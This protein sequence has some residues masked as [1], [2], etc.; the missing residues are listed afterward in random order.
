MAFNAVAALLAAEEVTATLVLSAMVE[1]GTTMSIVGAVTGSKDLMKLGGALAIVGGVGGLVNGAASAAGSSVVD[2]T[3]GL[4]TAVG[5]SVPGQI[6]ADAAGNTGI[7][8]STGG[9]EDVAA[10]A[11]DT[12]AS[13]ISTNATTNSLTP[14]SSTPMSPEQD[15]GTFAPN[16]QQANAMPGS[17]AAPGAQTATNQMQVQAPQ[18]P[19]SAGAEVVKAGA[20]APTD[21]LSKAASTD[22]TSYFSKFMDFVKKNKEV[23]NGILQLGGGLLKGMSDA[24]IADKKFGLDQQKINQ[25][26]FGNQVAS[27]AKPVGF[28]GAAQRG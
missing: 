18:T 17:T 14:P 19:A 3:G 2:A 16:G 8:A 23:S 28:V 9:I 1:V 10:G 25:T 20:S 13:T 22:S 6:A 7:L 12:G 21:V 11:V 15:N 24:S 26:S 4:E 5:G 27:Y